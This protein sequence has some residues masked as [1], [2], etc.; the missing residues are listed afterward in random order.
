MYTDRFRALLLTDSELIL[1]PIPKL[2]LDRFRSF[3]LT[4][5][6]VARWPIMSLCVDQ[7]WTY[8]L[9]DYEVARWPIPKIYVDRFRRCTSTDSEAVLHY[10]RLRSP[11]LI[12]PLARNKTKRKQRA[13]RV[14]CTTERAEKRFFFDRIMPMMVLFRGGDISQEFNAN[15]C[16]FLFFSSQ[17]LSPF[18][19]VL[20][21]WTVSAESRTTYRAYLFQDK[22]V[23]CPSSFSRHCMK[24]A[25]FFFPSHR[26]YRTSSSKPSPYISQLALRR[27]EFVE[28]HPVEYSQAVL[29]G[30]SQGRDTLELQQ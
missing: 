7:L 21:F 26:T 11:T 9:T 15:G 23:L 20:E 27:S 1:W 4:D 19:V 24:M 8:T 3:T 5:Y 25:C 16:F 6:E 12:D 22:Y 13:S 2:C 30:S 17:S 18:T 28:L 14:L 29:S 10:N